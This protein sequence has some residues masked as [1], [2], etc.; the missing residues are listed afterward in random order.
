M[1]QFIM[2]VVWLAAVLAGIAAF[3]LLIGV[4]G[5]WPAVVTLVVFVGF[6][7]FSTFRPQPGEKENYV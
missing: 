5:I 7:I 2:F 1:N 3:N 6:A 4:F